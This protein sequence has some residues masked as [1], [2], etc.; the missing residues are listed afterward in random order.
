M[1]QTLAQIR[2]RY[3][4][5]E[6]TLV[7]YEYEELC[8]EVRVEFAVLSWGSAD[9]WYEPGDPPELDIIEVTTMDG[10]LILCSDAGIE[11]LSE[12]LHE[13]FNA[14]DYDNDYY[15]DYE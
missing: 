7:L 2:S 14:N 8:F 9:G 6:E 5:F 3:R 15:G 11:R 13:T 4:C 12:A 1:P 10:A